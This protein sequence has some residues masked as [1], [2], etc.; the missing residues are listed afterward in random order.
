MESTMTE[1]ST[2]HACPPEPMETYD[3]SVHASVGDALWALLAEWDLDG[4]AVE[5]V[6]RGARLQPRTLAAILDRAPALGVTVVEVQA[7]QA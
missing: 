5:L 1:R 2:T 4:L 6:V 7:R 3:I